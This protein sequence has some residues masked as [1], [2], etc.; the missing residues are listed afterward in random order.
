VY[1]DGAWSS[2]GVE[3][4]AIL[5]S[6]SGVKLCYAARLQFTSETDKCTNNIAEYEAILSGLRKLRAIDIQTCMLYTDSKVVLGQIEKECIDREPT[7]EKYLALVR[8][9]ENYFKRF[10]VEYIK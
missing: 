10:T 2:A 7:L 8:R 1:C 4:A 6:P 5:V 3:A 9:M